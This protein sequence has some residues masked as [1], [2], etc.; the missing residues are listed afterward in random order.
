MSELAGVLARLYALASRGARHGLEAMREAC[1][2]EGDPQDALAVVHVAGTNGKGSVCA[3]LEAIARAAGIKTALYTSPHLGRFAERMR[4]DGEPI[5]DESLREALAHVLVTY[6]E[7]TFFEVATLAAFRAFRRAAVELAIVEVGLG[8]R[9]DATNVVTSPRATAIT[10]I[11]YDHTAILGQTIEEI[12]REKAGI[13]KPGV[14]LVTGPVPRAAAAVLEAR[15]QEV[16]AAPVWSV[17]RDV[18]HE[19]REG[20]LVVHGPAGRSVAAATKLRG[21]HQDDNAAIAVALAWLV[22]MPRPD[23]PAVRSIEEVAIARGLSQVNWPG[24]LEEV[25]REEGLLRGEYLLD[26][27]HNEEGV[28]AL[29][30]FLDARPADE[31]RA[32]VFGAMADK[33]WGAMLRELIPRFGARVYVEPLASGGGRPA[34]PTSALRAVD[35]EGEAAPRVEDAI[36]LARARVGEGGLVVVAGS[37]YLVGEARTVLLGVPRDPQVGL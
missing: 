21:A 23:R 2:A 11:A 31:R 24:R 22:R 25:R 20:H 30:A 15:A 6:P 37:L 27:A 33:A 36:A 18:T 26:G 32:L 19:R 5:D 12:A 4:I 1:A 14:P 9:L 3:S 10:T 7:L 35:P 28:H 17:G 34:T 16:G 29:G 8:G 13:L